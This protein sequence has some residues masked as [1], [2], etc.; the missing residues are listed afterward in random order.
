M[1][2]SIIAPR[3]HLVV[4]FDASQ[5]RCL[6]SLTVS[7][8]SGF[9]SETGQPLCKSIP[10][11]MDWTLIT[12]PLGS[13][14]QYMQGILEAWACFFIELIVGMILIWNFQ[15]AFNHYRISELLKVTRLPYTVHQHCVD[16]PV[17]LEG[18]PASAF[19][20]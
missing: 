7:V 15:S 19:P 2:S 3:R 20:S 10:R 16:Y 9:L 17:G 14:L 8:F 5:L 4:P 1:R 18:L 12:A 13:Q 6:L 11:Q